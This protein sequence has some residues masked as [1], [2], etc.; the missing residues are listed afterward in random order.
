MASCAVALLSG[1]AWA[2][3]DAEEPYQMVKRRR[4]REA[5]PS[6]SRQKKNKDSKEGGIRGVL[7]HKSA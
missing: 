4:C 5:P 7:E 2:L 3:R 6:M 1:A